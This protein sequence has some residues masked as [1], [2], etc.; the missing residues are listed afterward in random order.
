[1]VAV[2]DDGDVGVYEHDSLKG[3]N[4]KSVFASK[5]KGVN[6]MGET[7]YWDEFREVDDKRCQSTD[8]LA[9]NR[10]RDWLARIRWTL[11]L[12]SSKWAG[13]YSAKHTERPLTTGR[14]R[15]PAGCR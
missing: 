13:F 7:E 10:L 14:F 2:Y 5:G 6:R 3:W 12:A 11:V 9:I 4:H 8:T 1:V 15:I